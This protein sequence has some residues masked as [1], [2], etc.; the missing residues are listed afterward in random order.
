[1]SDQFLQQFVLIIP[2]MILTFVLS[3]MSLKAS[4]QD[5]RSP[6]GRAGYAFLTLA[7][8]ILGGIAYL[9]IIFNPQTLR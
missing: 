5:T 8:L 9:S 7:I 1:M 3:I 2:V 6:D 4:V